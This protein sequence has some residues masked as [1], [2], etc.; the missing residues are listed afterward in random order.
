MI[1]QKLKADAEAYLGGP[2]TEAVI[3]VPA[4]FN[5]AQRQATK[6]AGKIAGLESSVSSTSR[7]Q[8]RLPMALIRKPS[9]RSWSTTSAAARSMSPS[10]TSATASSKCLPPTATP[11]SAATIST[12]ASSSIWST[13]FKKAEGIDLSNDKVAMQRLK[14]AA[15]KAKDRAVRRDLLE[16]QPAVYHRRRNGPKHLDV[17]LTRAKF[18]ELTAHLVEAT[19]GPVKQ[20]MADAGLTANDISKSCWSAARAVS[21]QCRKRSR[22]SPVRKASRASTPT[23]AWPSARQSG[24]RPRRRREGSAAARCHSAVAGH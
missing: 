1:L 12:T 11:T 3:T 6:D 5:D 14:E 9:R 2:V 4:Y 23:S 10:W 21:R 24:R 15:E 16:H 8:R 20:A 22:S 19:M 7:R 13:R 17:T 18:N